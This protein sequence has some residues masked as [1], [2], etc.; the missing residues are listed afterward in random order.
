M[1]PQHALGGE[2]QTMQGMPLRVTAIG[3]QIPRPP[4]LDRQAE[5]T[6]V[7]FLALG[8]HRE[9]IADEQ[10]RHVLLVV[11]VHLHGAIDPAYRRARRRLGLDQHQ[12]QTIDQQHQVGP[13]FGAAGADR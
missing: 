7:I 1:R 9:H 5:R 11:V 3:I 10:L 4:V 12:R 13:A 8:G 6:V 2:L